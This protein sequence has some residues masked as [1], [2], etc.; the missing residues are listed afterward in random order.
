MSSSAPPSPRRTRS[1]IFSPTWCSS[2]AAT[3]SPSVVIFAPSAPTM[4]SPATMPPSARRVG[5]SPA[6]S[7]ADLGATDC[8]ST[9]AARTPSCFMTLGSATVIFSPGRVTRPNSM[10]CGTTRATRSTGMAKPTPALAPVLVK[11]AVFIPTSAPEASK[12][13]PPEFPGLIAASVWIPP[14][15]K[16]PAW[17]WIVRFKPETTPVVSVWSNPKGLPM[18]NTACPTRTFL[19]TPTVAGAKNSLGAFTL[20]TAKSLL[21]STP[22]SVALNVFVR[23]SGPK[24]VTLAHS[25]SARRFSGVTPKMAPRTW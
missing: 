11:M 24:S 20:I 5:N 19:L 7:A 21:L 13:A 17:L 22:T 12:S 8:T 6:F 15:I 23:P 1:V 16:L 9:P 14:L 18:A 2:T 3:R 4:T 25:K 10:S